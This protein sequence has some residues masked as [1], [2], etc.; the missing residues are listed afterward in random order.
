MYQEH[1]Q[2]EAPPFSIAP[3]PSFLYLSAG[4]TEA[5]AHLMYGFSHGGFVLITGEV[6]TGKT[7]LLRNLI[8]HTPPDLDVAFVLNPRLTVKELLETVCDELAVAHPESSD[9]TVKQYID[10]LNKHLLRTHNSGR[11]TVIIIDEA[12]NLSPSVLEQIR[13]L[14]N[15]ETDDRKLLRIILLGQPELG[16]L[17]DRTEL[18]QLAQRVT[19]RYHLGGLTREDCYAYVV[20]RLTRAG[21]NP[22]V[23]TRYAL[24]R[25]Y[26]I[27]KGIPRVINIVAD[28][29]MLGAYVEGRSQVTGRIVNRA[30][31]EV[32]GKRPQYRLWLVT[33][34]VSTFAAG[35]AF[36]YFYQPSPGPAA[37]PAAAVNA[38]QDTGA[39]AER[40]TSVRQKPALD[41]P[42]PT[43]AE[44][45]PAPASLSPPPESLEPP[46][47]TPTL[48][49]ES[50]RE[51]EFDSDSL[52]PIERPP[53][54][55]FS[56]QRHAYAAVFTTWGAHY[57]A[58]AAS[59]IPCNFAPSA[60]LQCLGLRGSWSDIV[61]MNL[62]VVLELWDSQARPYYAALIDRHGDRLS[63]RLGDESLIVTPRMLREVWSG[64]Y[65]LLW[66]TPPHY[67]GNIAAGDSHP[68]VG[69]L[70][71][72][73][74]GLVSMPLKSSSPNDF[75]SNL[76]SAVREF[77]NTEGL[78]TDGIVGPQTWIR[79]AD[80]LKLPAPILDG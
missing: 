30:A 47:V 29:A 19:A 56:S 33:G 57:D 67:H 16:A 78:L 12:Q 37:N 74:S 60:G 59:T 4:H 55:S 70:R 20:H 58:E 36:A 21:G 63:L 35:M 41:P 44:I 50:D 53:M 34:L 66:Q 26:R 8:K 9:P 77:Q 18:R 71:E 23:F 42:K 49:L 22:R 17:L 62:P 69:W 14:T 24:A 68:T 32:L 3:D 61:R 79:V 54:S 11:S 38:V 6:G 45:Q 7:T 48:R 46:V 52:T 31:N 51:R 65:V 76:D 64:R 80:R 72:Q 25:L 75:D 2:L 28:R 15:L 73:L 5:L 10:V 27:S 40:T 43:A 39:P 1:F 13:L